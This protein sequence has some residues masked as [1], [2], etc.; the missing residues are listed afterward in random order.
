M[1]VY[2]LPIPLLILFRFLYIG[3]SFVLMITAR[4]IIMAS[5]KRH[6]STLKTI[7][8]TFPEL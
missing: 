2:S 7:A 4:I 5:K 8:T 6:P 1:I 3:N